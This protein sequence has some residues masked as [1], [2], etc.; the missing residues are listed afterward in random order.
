ML[1]GSPHTPEKPESTEQQPDYGSWIFARTDETLP[2][3]YE[4]VH[5][6]RPENLIGASL[7]E[8][9]DDLWRVVAFLAPDLPHSIVYRQI[10]S[11]DLWYLCSDRLAG[12]YFCI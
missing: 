9:R 12:Y 8:N 5:A 11:F 7:L 2:V 1:G 6:K 3:V 4:A 10:L